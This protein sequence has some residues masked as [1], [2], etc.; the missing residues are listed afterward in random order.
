M[1]TTEVSAHNKLCYA[2]MH[3]CYVA[4]IEHV[5]LYWNSPISSSFDQFS[6]RFLEEINKYYARFLFCLSCSVHARGFSVIKCCSVLF[7]V[8]PFSLKLSPMNLL[9]LM[10]SYVSQN[11]FQ[12]PPRKPA[13]TCSIQKVFPVGKK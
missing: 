11:T 4:N 2:V 12:Q 3:L 10:I 1:M 7:L 8:C 9:N 5:T 6:T 13:L